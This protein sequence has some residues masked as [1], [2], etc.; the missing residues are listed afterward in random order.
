MKQVFI[1]FS[2][3]CTSAWAHPLDLAVL[4][5]N[6]QGPEIE[7]SLEMN[8]AH[9]VLI[10]ELEKASFALDGRTCEAKGRPT[11]QLQNPQVMSAKM[12]IRCRSDAGTL[13]ISLPFL[14]KMGPSYRLMYMS[15]LNGVEHFGDAT[16]SAPGIRIAVDAP[17]SSPLKFIEM[18]M[19]HIGVAQS[20]WSGPQ[21][22]HF[23]EG[24][25]HIL[26]VVALVLGG[27]GLM[28]LLKTV[29]GFTLGHS[30][31]LALATLGLVHMPSRLV[32]AAIALSIAVV[33]AESLFLKE[34]RHRWKIALGFGMLHGLGFASAL[35]ELHLDRGKILTALIGFNVGV[36]IGQSVIVACLLP[37]VYF[38][39]NHQLSR[40]FA[41]P[42]CTAAIFL[43]SSFWFVQRALGH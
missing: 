16:P 4:N 23:P 26:F 5:L 17:P 20:E 13:A 41:L 25:D 6:G 19:T 18:G 37:C 42:A 39:R 14:A 7:V 36:E 2:L 29:T 34:S 1:L 10:L 15:R 43:T 40:R 33:A 38:M 11:V 12:S 28:G 27:G 3:F 24:L 8:P 35:A 22:M 30:I 32:E 9:Q 31:T 21:G